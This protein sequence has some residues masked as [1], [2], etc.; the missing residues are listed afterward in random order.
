MFEKLSSKRKSEH[1][2]E[3]ILSAIRRGDYQIGDKLPPE[4]E[5]AEMIGVSRPSV[6][7]ALGALR[8]VGILETKIGDGTYIKNDTWVKRGGIDIET[9]LISMLESE[10]DPFAALE[11]RRA[12]ET[13]LLAY[14]VERR[15]R[16][17]LE[18]ME[19]ALR[20]ILGSIEAKRYDDLLRADRDFHLAIARASQNSVLIR[21]LTS[22]FDIMERSLWPRM[23]KELLQ[24][25]QR[26]LEETR[27]SHRELYQ[28]IRAKDKA[29]AIQIMER[30]FEEIESLL[31]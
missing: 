8:L 10:E 2:V 23:K 18:E 30:H 15:G 29:R 13:G 1:V 11:S 19:S 14:A 3:Q 16:E 17:D 9:K 12:L 5:I 22:L 27:R 28:A 26:H 4:E 31:R 6:R 21:T 24:A 7:E 25:G 20:R